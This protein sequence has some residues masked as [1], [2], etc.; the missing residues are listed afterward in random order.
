MCKP[1]DLSVLKQT[2][3]EEQYRP[4]R[5]ARYPSVPKRYDDIRSRGRKPLI[6]DCG[7]N[8]EL[9]AA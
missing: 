8:F 7:A 1:I 3:L 2:L 4:S 6:V 9:S 5:L